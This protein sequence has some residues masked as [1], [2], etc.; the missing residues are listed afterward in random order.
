MF[1]YGF[2]VQFFD[3]FRVDFWLKN[4]IKRNGFG[5]VGILG[6]ETLVIYTVLA[7]CFFDA[8]ETAIKRMVL[9]PS[10][11]QTLAI[12]NISGPRA[13]EIAGK[14]ILF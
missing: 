5:R 12:S 9:R 13:F 6:P 3:F 7:F 8:P 10:I 1:Y 4:D 11:A 14:P 2:G